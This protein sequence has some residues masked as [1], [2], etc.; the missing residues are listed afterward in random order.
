MRVVEKEEAVKGEAVKGRAERISLVRKE[1]SPGCSIVRYV[2]KPSQD[3]IT[4]PAH[5]VCKSIPHAMS[6]SR[7][8]AD[9]LPITLPFFQRHLRKC[10]H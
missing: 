8:H 3:L 1:A 9:L 5:L 7:F 4:V 2:C 10:T 6:L